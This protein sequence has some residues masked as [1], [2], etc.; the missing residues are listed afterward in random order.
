MGEFKWRAT[1]GEVD[2]MGESQKKL[3]FWHLRLTLN[4]KMSA[5]VR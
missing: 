1:E 4:V 3:G 2:N 5:Y